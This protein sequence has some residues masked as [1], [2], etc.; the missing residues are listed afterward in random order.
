MAGVARSLTI[1][2]VFVVVVAGPALAQ[3]DESGRFAGRDIKWWIA[4]LAD[5]DEYRAAQSALLKIG[6]PAQKPLAE[7]LQRW[8]LSAG[9]NSIR[10]PSST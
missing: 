3:Q 9:C 5:D 1:I 2:A 8:R 7:A 6:R 4:Q 10:P